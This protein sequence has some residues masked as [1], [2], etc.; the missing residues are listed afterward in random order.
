MAIK[1]LQS[2]PVFNK[3][4]GIVQPSNA[5][6]RAGQTIEQLGTSMMQNFFEK[7]VNVQKQ[8]GADVA[9]NFRTRDPNGK[10][11]YRS[12]PEGL[13]KVAQREAQ[14][15][16]DK[17]Y[18]AAL[19]RD[20][21]N[22]AK[23]LRA[24]HDKDPDGF[25][26]AFSAYVNKTAELTD[27]RYKALATDMGAEIAGE[28][29]AA[30]YADKVDA[31]DAQDYK[32]MYN[33]IIQKSDELEAFISNGASVSD[34][35]VAHATYMNL[36][37]EVDELVDMH[38]DRMSV[39][40]ATNLKTTLKRQYGGSM[41]NSVFNKL[42]DLPQFQDVAIGGEL[43]ASVMNGLE[44]AFR[45]GSLDGLEPSVVKLLIDAGFSERMISS[46]LF[47][48][49]DR[50]VI[51]GDI[52]VAENMFQ[53]RLTA[54]RDS[55]R[56]DATLRVVNGGGLVSKDD[57][58]NLFA[59]EGI[60]D[61][62]SL[63]NN[64]GNILNPANASTKPIRNILLHSNSDLPTVVQNLFTT[65]NLE[66]LANTGQLPMVMD[67]FSQ[68]TQRMNKDGSGANTVT[69]G[70]SDKVIVEMEALNA[71]RNSVKEVSFEEYYQRRGEL[72]RNPQ[73]KE[74]LNA[75]LGMNGDKQI[76]IADFVNDQLDSDASPEEAAYY[77]QYAEDLVLMHGKEM[78]GDILHQSSKRVFMKSPFIM[79]EGRSRYAPE[80]A[81]PSRTDMDIFKT[82]TQS[83]L[84]TA[85]DYTLGE[86]AFLIPDPRH[87]VV[88]PVYMIVDKNKMPIMSGSQP[89]F[90]SGQAVVEQRMKMKNQTA[91]ELRKKMREEQQR[92]LSFR[93]TKN[94]E[95]PQGR[96]NQTQGELLD[97]IAGRK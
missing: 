24:D 77:M 70:I 22:E 67:L 92:R 21:T 41:A 85:G 26:K 9:R 71:Y 1:R 83:L 93:E 18:S 65:D 23:R 10:I 56:A 32:N 76:K 15:I 97:E 95:R 31:D 39:T 59:Q 45:V 20:M 82:H 50:R 87:G 58:D 88:N 17:K 28:N 53:E 43:A 62:E 74:I 35:S 37:R 19:L 16:I 86:N 55:R 36:V 33:A 52:S 54:T 84:D 27:S 64:L 14:P 5:G 51:A 66:K 29:T 89:L 80:K 78:A 96:I 79:G 34:S 68:A 63:M 94:E 47:D 12:L 75:K 38:G 25:D 72:A 49:E 2:Q 8:K 4:I 73:R 69:R 81:F 6:V 48:A 40:Q 90:A 3:P 46:D 30:I 11:E 42:T 44:Q 57:M 91:D 61:V 7:E 60:R 13:S